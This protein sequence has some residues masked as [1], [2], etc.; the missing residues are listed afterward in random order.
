MHCSTCQKVLFF[1]S[2]LFC[3]TLEE[4]KE[5]LFRAKTAEFGSTEKWW[6]KGEK[7]ER[8]GRRKKEIVP[9][10]T[11]IGK[12]AELIVNKSSAN[13]FFAKLKNSSR[14]IGTRSVNQWLLGQKL[15]YS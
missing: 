5:H 14:P 13:V 8:K 10:N 3:V 4:L 6:G 2:Y 7:E 1:F 11:N 12:R 15:C 9:K